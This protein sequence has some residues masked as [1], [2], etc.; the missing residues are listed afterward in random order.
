M[1]KFGSAFLVF[2][3]VG[4]FTVRN[5]SN[6]TRFRANIL[7]WERNIFESAA[8]GL[9]LF[10]VARLL[11]IPDILTLVEGHR[12][13]PGVALGIREFK[14][15]LPFP[16]AGSLIV[17]LG[18]GVLGAKVSNLWWRPIPEVRRAIQNHG[19]DLRAFLHNAAER[20]SPVSLTM[21][22]RKV[23]VGLVVQAPG[24]QEP[25]YVKILPTLSG[26]RDE[27]TLAVV[28]N[29]PYLRVYEDISKRRAAGEKLSVEMA[30][31][32]FVLPLGSI[33]SANEFDNDIYSRHFSV[34][35]PP[36]SAP[37]NSNDS[38]AQ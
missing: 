10:V 25:S 36:E 9:V 8:V 1:E 14:T 7:Q 24:L 13:G 16:F 37:A 12:L 31:F 21:S 17:T 5:L 28:F 26:Y 11:V 18:L 15:Y 35:P 3:I 30:N 27:R 32:V 29:T 6:R 19:G 20:G 22:N 33:E 34:A 23:Y 4:Y 2:A 38:P